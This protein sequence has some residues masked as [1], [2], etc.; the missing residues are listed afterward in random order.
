M[1]QIFIFRVCRHGYLE[2]NAIQR[3]P[4]CSCGNHLK[5]ILTV[6]ETL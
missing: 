1:I 2:I 6:S 4:A 5:K 3:S